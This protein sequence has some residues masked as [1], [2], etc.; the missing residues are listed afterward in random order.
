MRIKGVIPTHTSTGP[1][2][3]AM[4]AL[5]RRSGIELSPFQLDQLWTYHQLLRDF[6]PQLN[7]TRIHNFSNMVLKLYV[8][9]MLP[10]QMIDLPSPLLDLGTGAGMPGIPLKIFMPHLEILLAES[11]KNRS[12]F[13][14]EAVSRLKLQDVQVVAEGIHPGSEYPVNGVIT[15]AVESVSATLNR[16][17]GCLSRRGLAIFMK[18]PRCG[19]EID[20][21][22]ERHRR[23]YRLVRDVAYSIP[24]T[25]HE[26]R[27]VVFERLDEPAWSSR[28]AAMKR[29]PYRKIESEHNEIFKDLKKLHA[30]RGIRKQGQALV[31]GRKLIGEV[32]RD[33]PELCKAWISSDDRSPPPADA[34]AHIAWI[35]LATS[36]FRTLDLFGTGAPL[37]QVETPEINE[38]DPSSGFPPGCSI[39]IPF[40]DP[41]NVGT[42]IRSAAAFGAAR[43]ILLSESAHPWHPRALR[44]S[45]GAVFHVELLHGPSVHDLPE[46]LPVVPLSAEGRDIS[47]FD[48][49]EAFGL[50]PGMEGPGLPDRWRKHCVSIP[51]LPSVESLNA[52]TAAAIALFVWSREK[53]QRGTPAE[54]QP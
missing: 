28:A 17:E 32:L 37:L 54:A 51:I 8:D 34:P 2:P 50:L 27:L 20:E 30:S 25:A 22:V 41:E 5:L 42:L 35:Q 33:F 12:E 53:R 19:D 52:A 29:H 38:W 40:Q 10:A 14:E 6:N 16:I 44:A 23:T 24:G 7:L 26:R 13:I 4:S 39:L 15:R 47:G 49:P 45:G 31:C 46:D 9:S 21:A 18:G 3:E 43:V 36:L 1:G 48:F 11:R